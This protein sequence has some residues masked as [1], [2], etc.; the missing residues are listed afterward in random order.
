MQSSLGTGAAAVRFQDELLGAV[1][2]VNYNQDSLNALAGRQ[3]C[4]LLPGSMPITELAALL[5]VQLH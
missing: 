5:Q 1:N 3:A 2:R 4:S